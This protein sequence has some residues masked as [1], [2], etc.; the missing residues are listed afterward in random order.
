MLAAEATSC[1]A[2][3]ATEGQE[4]QAAEAAMVAMVGQD[5]HHQE[6]QEVH[7]QVHSRQGAE[8]QAKHK[9][10]DCPDSDDSE[11]EAEGVEEAGNHRSLEDLQDHRNLNQDTQKS[12]ADSHLND[13]LAPDLSSDSSQRNCREQKAC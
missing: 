4:N 1:S 12:E 9:D 11:M 8:S 10:K 7:D 2:V 6:D 13:L 5:L 3:E